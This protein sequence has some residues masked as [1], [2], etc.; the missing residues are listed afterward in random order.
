MRQELDTALRQAEELR[1]ARKQF[2][3]HELAIVFRCRQNVTRL[4]FW[5]N[6]SWISLIEGS[7]QNSNIIGDFGDADLAISAS[8]P[9]TS[10]PNFRLHRN[11]FANLSV[12]KN[13][14]QRETTED[15]GEF[16]QTK[17]SV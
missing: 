7:F 4:Y 3:Y 14:T 10:L 1:A 13:C 15:G 8:S 6:I 12:N 5:L 16:D 11:T 2:L 17:R 9:S